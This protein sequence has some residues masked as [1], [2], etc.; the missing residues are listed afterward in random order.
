M[1]LGTLA[2]LCH[3]LHTSGTVCSLARPLSGSVM[4]R[5]C[6]F[7]GMQGWKVMDSLKCSK[8]PNSQTSGVYADT[9]AH[10]LLMCSRS[11]LRITKESCI[12]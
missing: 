3:A 10:A 4:S 7:M 9:G 12:I 2:A 11:K 8:L 1:R 6:L 5:S